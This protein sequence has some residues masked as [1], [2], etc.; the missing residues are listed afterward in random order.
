M[1]WRSRM[2]GLWL[3]P[4]KSADFRSILGEGKLTG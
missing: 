1:R 4:G 3:L 2:T